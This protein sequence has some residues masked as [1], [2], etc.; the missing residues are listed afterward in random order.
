VDVDNVR[1]TAE[2][3]VPSNPIPLLNPDFEAPV[4]ADGAI[5]GP[6]TGWTGGSG[7]YNPSGPYYATL[8]T[9]PTTGTMAGPNVGFMWGL[10]PPPLQQITGTQAVAGARYRLTVALG[11]RSLNNTF[12]G[13]AIELL[14]N[15]AVVASR[16]VTA[17]PVP[18]SFGDVSVDW[19]APA[20]ADGALLG[21][22]IR[23]IT[24]SDNG[25]VDVDNV[26]LTTDA[27]TPSTPIA[28]SNPDF[29][30]QLLADGAIAAGPTGWTGGS[31]VYNPSGPYYATLAN[32]STTGT[33]AGANVGYLWGSAP[34]LE[35]QITTTR[36]VAG[37]RYQ[38]TVALG[39][40]NPGR[41]A[42]AAIELLANGAVVAR[43]AVTAL[44]APGSFGDVSVDWTAPAAAH[45]AR[46]GLRIRALMSL[47]D[48]Y[49]DVDNV[50]LSVS[51]PTTASP[52]SDD[53]L[54]KRGVAGADVV[55]LMGQSNMSGYGFA[56]DA[57]IDGPNNPRI[58]QWS[59][60]GAPIMASEHLEHADHVPGMTNL[61]MG[62]AFGR[63][64][65]ATLP[66]Q[67]QVLLVPAAYQGTHLVN[68]RWTPG[69]DLF[70]DAVRRLKAAVAS[71]PGNCV[72]AVLWHQGESDVM[73]RVAS[74]TYQAALTQMIGSLRTRV[75]RAAKA[76]LVVGQFTPLWT[77]EVRGAAPVDG[78]LQA[79][80]N[81]PLE[82]G[83]SAVASSQGLSTE[84]GVSVH[85][86]AVALR[87]Y[88]QR[89][90]DMLPAALANVR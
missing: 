52:V 43:R 21:V 77:A 69:A 78:V 46:L 32:E 82:V 70:E 12:D 8:T 74:A 29:E 13:A 20:A 23:A 47:A 72:A 61:G 26:R 66:A 11:G 75:P 6:P 90:F 81:I 17:L 51:N 3:L 45:G 42:G 58:L 87:T 19:T 50:R 53:C 54:A 55:L 15:G 33:M 86:D 7:T 38:L 67:R 76:P 41:F 63:A 18:G 80:R 60:A 28:L 39:G 49:V 65:L 48:G 30:G 62:T 73:N 14:A 88:G 56:Y 57:S 5:V 27:V 84:P 71:Q 40:R 16:S 68:G 85:F 64:Y 37:A 31:G 59:R 83:T 24:S 89:Y 9:D 4:L 1:L 79:L 25:F 44:P 36:A 22:R 34:P 10:A 2:A 35:Q